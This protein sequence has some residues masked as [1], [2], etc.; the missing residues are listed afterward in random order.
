MSV[1]V[2][3]CSLEWGQ[4]DHHHAPDS[5]DAGIA[6]PTMPDASPDAAVPS[7]S[8]VAST[9]TFAART[10]YAVMDD[11]PYALVIADL[12]GNGRPDV[13][14]ANHRHQGNADTINTLGS[15]TALL[16]TPSGGLQYAGK[17]GVGYGPVAIAA[18]DFNRDGKPDLV[19][20]NL[21]QGIGGNLSLLIGLGG[22]AFAAAVSAAGCCSP[23]GIR[24]ADMNGDLAIANYQSIQISLGNGLG[25]FAAPVSY[26]MP[27]GGTFNLALGDLDHNG[28]VDVVGDYGYWDQPNGVAVLLGNTNGSLQTSVGYDSRKGINMQAMADIDHDGALDVITSNNA[29]NDISVFRGTGTGTLLM[30]TTYMSGHALTSIVAADFNGDT[31]ADI[32]VTAADDGTV[33]V[34]LNKGDGTFDI[35]TAYSTGSGAFS[36]AAADFNGDRRLDLVVANPAD[37]T[38]SVLLGQP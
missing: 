25:G 23:Q 9:G 18:G 1:M 33:L 24:T 7:N 27:S 16:S 14:V 29:T 34:M 36:V 11:E 10:A 8:L 4:A 20:A 31:Y 3:G 32:A 37:D 30:P 15:V 26:A 13:A 19:T 22:G 38:V 17:A 21:A 12:D 28:T 2:A 6:D 35:A 5:P